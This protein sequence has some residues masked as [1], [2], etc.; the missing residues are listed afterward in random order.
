[1]ANI[2]QVTG[3]AVDLPDSPVAN[4]SRVTGSAVLCSSF[5]FYLQVCTK[6]KTPKGQVFNKP[7]VLHFSKFKFVSLALNIDHI[8]D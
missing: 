4:I 1:M 3:S 5:C 8:L 6:K 7:N 2:S